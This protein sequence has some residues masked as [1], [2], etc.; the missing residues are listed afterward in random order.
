MH[1]AADAVTDI[2]TDHSVAIGP[3]GLLDGMADVAEPL[4]VPRLGDPV[5]QRSLGDLEQLGHLGRHIADGH[6]ICSVPVPTL[7]DGAG[8]DRDDVAFTQAIVARNA[9][10]DDLVGR[11]ADRRRESVVAEEGGTALPLTKDLGGN[12]VELAQ[13]CA[14]LGGLASRGVDRGDTGAGHGHLR[15]V[16]RA[17][18]GDYPGV[19]LHQLAA[20]AFTMRLNTSST[21]PI[22]STMTTWT[23]LSG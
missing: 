22:P 23:P 18:P 8:I 19:R 9:V 6:R 3:G 12:R 5:P 16:F 1:L 13:R 7:V 21:V 20:N 11:G 15:K 2:V 10:H 17:L 4:A 14:G